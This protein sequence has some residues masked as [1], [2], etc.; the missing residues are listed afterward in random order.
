MLL[1]Q[2]HKI[3]TDTMVPAESKNVCIRRIQIAL[4]Y[5]YLFIYLFVVKVAYCHYSQ[6]DS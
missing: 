4:T 1:Y 5:I 2:P 6:T 3:I